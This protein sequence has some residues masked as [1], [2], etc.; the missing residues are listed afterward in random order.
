MELGE[1]LTDL[2]KEDKAR[3]DR[4]LF[5]VER[6]LNIS[7]RWLNITEACRYAKM[8]KNTLM[9]CILDG[10]IKASKPRGKWI[11]DRLSID[12]YYTDEF[13][14]VLTRDRLDPWGGPSDEPSGT[15]G[16]AN[17]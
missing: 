7:Q 15:G 1:R 12:T 6:L 10:Y 9:E 3:A 2:E 13:A 17:E 8:S 11:V 5:S 14:S 4:I 16:V